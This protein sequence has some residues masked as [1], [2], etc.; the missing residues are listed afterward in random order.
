M[1]KDEIGKKYGLLTVIEET[2]IREP[3]NGCIKWRCRCACGNEIIVNGNLL[4]FNQVQ[5]CGC[6]VYRKRR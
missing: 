2:D 5:S 3:S 1:K 6:L 4:R